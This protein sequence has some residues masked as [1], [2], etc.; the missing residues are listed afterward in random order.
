MN[1]LS[2][3]LAV[4]PVLSG[5]D[6]R[7]QVRLDNGGGQLRYSIAYDGKNLVEPSLLGL[8]TNEAD[9]T[10]LEFLSADTQEVRVTYT[11][12]RI[13]ASRIDHPAVKNGLT[14]CIVEPGLGV[15]S[16]ILG[17]YLLAREAEEARA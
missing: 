17:A 1:I 4:L 3:L 10:R 5:P 9:Y 14:D 2:I 7:L 12:D 11:L 15:N 8:Q 13:K 16:G 6:G